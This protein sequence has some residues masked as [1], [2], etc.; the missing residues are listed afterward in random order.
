MSDLGEGQRLLA[1]VRV[2]WK[3]NRL[4][5]PTAGGKSIVG[6]DADGDACIADPVVAAL[7]VFLVN[8]ADA[9]LDL[10]A[11]TAEMARLGPVTTEVRAALARLEGP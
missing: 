9:L 1:E 3:L 6:I 5:Y 2:P 8:R 10:W 4:C 11:W 7:I